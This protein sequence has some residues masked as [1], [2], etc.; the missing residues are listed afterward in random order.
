LAGCGTDSPSRPDFEIEPGF[1]LIEGHPSWSTNSVSWQDLASGTSRFAFISVSLEAPDGAPSHFLYD[2]EFSLRCASEECFPLADQVFVQAGLTMSSLDWSPRGALAVFEGKLDVGMPTGFWIYTHA[3][4]GQP[5]RWAKGFEPSFSADAGLVFYVEE[6]RDAIRS[7]NP[8]SGGGFVERPDLQSAA[9]PR[10]SPD[11]RYIAYSAQ[12]LARGRRIL[13]HDRDNSTFLADPVSDP[14]R[15][16]TGAPGRDGIEDDYPTWSPRG[17]YIAFRGRAGQSTIRD[18]IFLTEWAREPENPVGLVLISPGRKMTYLRWHS[19]G[20][21]LLAII[22]GNVYV[23][24]V[25]E[26]YWDRE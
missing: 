5:R 12:D 11:G 9:H 20:L 26:R 4:G 7:F 21:Y 25:P 14:D 19:S 16:P 6:G 22:D 23:F 10:V 15:L 17:R 8:S 3:P 24:Q 1:S 18:G 2:A 13:V